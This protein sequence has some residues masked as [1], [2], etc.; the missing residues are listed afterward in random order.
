[1][2]TALVVLD[3]FRKD[4]F[5]EHFDWLPGTRYE[6]AWS[7]SHWTIPSHVSLFTG[8]Y[9]SEVGTFARSMTLDHGGETLAE[10]LSA[11]GY[12]THAFSA[13]IGISP[14]FGFDRG[15]D[16]F[17]KSERVEYA[18]RELLDWSLFLERHGDKSPHRYL[19]ALKEC[20]ESDVDTIGSLQRGIELKLGDLGIEVGA[21]D[22]G[23]RSAL[24]FVRSTDFGDRE[25]LFVNLMEAHGPFDPP[26]EYRTVDD[27]EMPSNSL[28][29]DLDDEIDREPV[30]TA[31]NDSVRYLSDMYREIFT[32][33]AADFDR[34][35]T[36]ADHGNAFGERDVYGH[37]YGLQPELTHVPLCVTDTTDWEDSSAA[38]REDDWIEDEL[39][40][41]LDVHRTILD[42]AD[43]DGDSDGRSLIDGET[44]RPVLTEY[45]GITQPEKIDNLR[46]DGWDETRIQEYD[47][48]L[49]GVVLPPDRYG[50]QTHDGVVTVDG[51]D[52]ETVETEIERLTA[53]LDRVE[54]DEDD[55]LDDAVLQ[56]LEDLGYA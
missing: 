1:M 15:F 30:W 40:S 24:N 5:D 53:E 13:N 18:A 45:H 7:T 16:R 52:K 37:T 39:V 8:R 32:E 4:A 42:L 54:R 23:A 36:L 25:F 27:Y 19:I 33:I 49:D 28:G 10:A 22:D 34:V 35:I 9:A 3:T 38:E 48:P 43:V 29:L 6:N 11:A 55:D 26:K 31:Y 56:Q 50:Y 12:T 46:R 44:S 14:I 47:R 51:L 2:N 21:E 20:L 17:E 41:L